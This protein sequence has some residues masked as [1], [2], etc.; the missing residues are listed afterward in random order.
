MKA[1]WTIFLLLGLSIV[2]L[3]S[4]STEKL[5]EPLIGK[6]VWAEGSRTISPDGFERLHRDRSSTYLV[7]DAEF[8]FDFDEEGTFKSS[9]NIPGRPGQNFLGRWNKTGEQIILDYTQPSDFTGITEYRVHNL[10]DINLDLQWSVSYLEFTDSQIA[11][12]QADGTIGRD[13]WMVDK[14][15]LLEEF[16]TNITAEITLHFVKQTE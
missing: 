3:I 16:G 11:A 1:K 15:S 5:S 13:G 2:S 6:W 14:V 7:G 10:D 12:W 9:Y 4:C 8:F